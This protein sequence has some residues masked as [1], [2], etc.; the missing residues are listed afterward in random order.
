MAFTR[1]FVE[2]GPHKKDSLVKLPYFSELSRPFLNLQT[3]HFKHLTKILKQIKKEYIHL[4]PESGEVIRH[5]LNIFLLKSKMFY[6]KENQDKPGNVT[7]S[8]GMLYSGILF[9]IV[10]LAL[11]ASFFINILIYFQTK[12]GVS[13]RF[14]DCNTMPFKWTF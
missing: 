10:F 2:M 3:E 6:R 9:V 11:S 8:L 5:Y 4:Q 14:N 7:F 12:P 13:N 1:E